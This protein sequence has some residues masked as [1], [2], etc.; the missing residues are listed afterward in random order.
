MKKAPFYLFPLFLIACSESNPLPDRF[1]PKIQS[2]AFVVPQLAAVPGLTGI[3]ARDCGSCHKAI[4]K[5]WSATTHA[6]ALRDIQF[7]AELSKKDSPKWLCLNCHIPLQNQRAHKI[8]GLRNNDVFQPILEPNPGFD[9]ELQKEGVTCAACHIRPNLSGTGSVIIGPRGTGLAP[10]PVRKDKKHLQNVCL[11]CHEPQGERLTPNLVCW[12]TPEAELHEAR[13]RGKPAAEKSCV[14]CHMPRTRRLLAEDFP[15]PIRNSPGHHWV[16]GGIPKFYEGYETLLKRGFKSA[17]RVRVRNPR[18][19]SGGAEIRMDINLANKGAGHYLP[20]GDPERHILAQLSL[21]NTRGVRLA[22]K[23]LRIGQTW[24]WNPARK[25]GDN[26]LK[27]GEERL[28]KP[29]LKLPAA[30]AGLRVVLTI[31]HVKI[32]SATARHMKAARNINQTFLPDGQNLVKNAEKYYPFASVIYREDFSLPGFKRRKYS[33]KEL[34]E[35]SMQ[36]NN[37]PLN[38]RDY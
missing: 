36:E 19:H 13:R 1:D 29:F 10:H 35:F 34:I 23:R 21:E 11:R 25:V 2:Y 9:P 28:W 18:I 16:G 12:F 7:Q 20:T 15:T 31:Y 5:E 38:K 22:V 17:L 27:E 30:G 8:L 32:T 24:N 4:Y 37:K 14:Q 26:R 3:K 6:A 33:A